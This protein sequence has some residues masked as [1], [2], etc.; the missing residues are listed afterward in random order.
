MN[1]LRTLIIDRLNNDDYHSYSMKHGTISYFDYLTNL[2]EE[3][4]DT[5]LYMGR[6]D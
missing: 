2:N 6:Y 1:N 4:V 5:I 3:L